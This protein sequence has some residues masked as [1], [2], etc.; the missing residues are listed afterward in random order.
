[1]EL[2]KARQTENADAEIRRMMEAYGSS[3]LR[4]CFLYLKDASLAEDAVQES[5][6]KAYRHLGDFR[7]ESGEKTWLMRIAINTCKDFHRSAWARLVDRRVALDGIRPAAEAGEPDDDTVIREV[8]RLDA[9][10]KEV[11]LLKYYQNM[12]IAEIGETLG[13]PKGTVTSRL[14]RARGKLHRRLKGW[15]FDE[16]EL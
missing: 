15:Y 7:G 4:M 6:W 16:Q 3:M 13:I 9:K 12:K 10:D 14:N 1:M 11:I 2:A 8:M 5:F